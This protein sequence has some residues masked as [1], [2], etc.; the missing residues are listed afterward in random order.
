MVWACGENGRGQPCEGDE[1]NGG[2]SKIQRQRVT[3]VKRLCGERYEDCV[4][5]GGGR[6]R[7]EF[8]TTTY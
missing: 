2:R 7:Q 4:A 5:G 1:A 6:E 8:L 3:E